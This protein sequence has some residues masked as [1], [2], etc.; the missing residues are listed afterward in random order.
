MIL[1][2]AWIVFPSAIALIFAQE[3]TRLTKKLLAVRGAKLVLPLVLGSLLIELYQGWG[4]WIVLYT[5][6]NCHNWLQHME[7]ILTFKVVLVLLIKS[8]ILFFLG[9]MPVFISW[10][11]AKRQ[12]LY[13]IPVVSYYI[14]AVLW[15]LAS[16]IFIV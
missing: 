12:G 11:N 14:G 13:A 8:A 10:L 9:S 15:L 7:E 16:C 2:F 6:A 3:L 4:N 1:T 5:Q